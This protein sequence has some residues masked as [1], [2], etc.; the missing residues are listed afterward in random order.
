MIYE[1]KSILPIVGL[2][3]CDVDL[4]WEEVR[5]VSYPHLNEKAEHRFRPVLDHRVK[6][7]A[8]ERHY[9]DKDYRDTFSHYHSKRFSTPF[10]R[11]IRL[12]FFSESYQ[13]DD[14]LNSKSVQ[15]GYL[16]YS[17]IRPTRPN[18][19]GRTLI[20]PDH[21]LLGEADISM[22]EECVCLL[23]C[24]LK[25]KGFPFISQDADV[26]VCAQSAL[27]ML[28]RYFSDRYSIYA[29]T[30]PYQIGQLTTDY[31]IGR[32]YP[33][34]GLQMW[35]MSEALKRFGF[36][37]LIYNRD[38][39]PSDEFERLLYTYIE[40][41][42]PSLIG[43]PN[44]VIVG[45]G[46]HS[47]FKK[48]MSSDEENRIFSS[49]F[50]DAFIVSDDNAFPYQALM[51]QGG[52]FPQSRLSF[53]DI[54]SFVVPLPE[55]VFLPAEAAQAGIQRVL[56]EFRP[57]SAMFADKPMIM[58]TF[59]TSVRSFKEHVLGRGMGNPVVLEAY[60]Q[61]PMPHFVWVCEFS[62]LSDYP[63]QVWG[64]LVWDA[65]RNAHEPGGWIALHFPE[66]CFI[67][68]GSAL[69]GVQEIR[70]IPLQNSESYPIFVSNLER[71]NDNLC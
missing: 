25:V 53:T 57:M 47:D 40:S 18:A 30:G 2:E 21:H 23:G 54:D 60:R 12:H 27:W 42:L 36:H 33:S 58:R 24:R 14:F 52:Q 38:N 61:L 46:H 20:A 62:T 50:N 49:K 7:V 1:E 35:Q 17:V 3:E 69:N 70:Q 16:G 48:S 31:S 37:P 19:V 39:Y 26:T 66:F 68:I 59:L 28:C 64:E 11:C 13:R 34:S 4:L 29:E 43:V 9:I 55:K 22:T 41:G 44:H 6:T 51:R 63:D 71:M 65:T 10:S 67:D 5:K 32:M 8:V 56:K 45:Y 15:E